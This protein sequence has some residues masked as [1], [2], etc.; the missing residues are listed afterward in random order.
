VFVPQVLEAVGRKDLWNAAPVRGGAQVQ[1]STSALT[2]L[3]AIHF[4]QLRRDLKPLD[5]RRFCD[6]RSAIF[7]A[8][9]SNHFPHDFSFFPCARRTPSDSHGAWSVH[10]QLP[11]RNMQP[12]FVHTLA[13]QL[14]SLQR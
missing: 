7:L 2:P 14:Q 3:L 8:H 1:I 6:K 9:F 12:C 5:F 4:K 10:P 13:Q 11:V